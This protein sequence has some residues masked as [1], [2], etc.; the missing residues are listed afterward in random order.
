M[1]LGELLRTPRG[2]AEAAAL[3]AS[4]LGMLPFL[5]FEVLWKEVNVVEAD[6]RG[7]LT[8]DGSNVRLTTASVRC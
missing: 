3:S 1:S 6:I 7:T 4:L 5:Y 2:I 8:A